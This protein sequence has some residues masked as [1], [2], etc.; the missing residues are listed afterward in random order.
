MFIKLVFVYSENQ[1]E[2]SRLSN[3]VRW[4][5]EYHVLLNYK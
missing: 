1:L 3:V 5:Y 4:P 2:I